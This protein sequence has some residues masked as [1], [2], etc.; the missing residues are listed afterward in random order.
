MKDKI[1]NES[2]RIYSILLLLVAIGPIVKAAISDFNEI[3]KLSPEDYTSFTAEQKASILTSASEN[4]RDI[5]IKVPDKG[6]IASKESLQRII[7]LRKWLE[8]TNDVIARTLSLE[9]Q[10]GVDS[11]IINELY[12][13]E[14]KKH[15]RVLKKPF[16]DT[17]LDA[18]TVTMLLK[19]NEID[20]KELLNYTLKLDTKTTNY[21]RGNGVD[22]NDIINDVVDIPLEYF[23]VSITMMVEGSMC[24]VLEETDV[25]DA[26]LLTII[27]WTG[28]KVKSRREISK[29]FLS[30]V[31]KAI[32]EARDIRL[33]S[34]IYINND[35]FVKTLKSDELILEDNAF[36][37]NIKS[38]LND[39]NV[40]KRFTRTGAIKGV[41]KDAKRSQELWTMK[42]LGKIE[43]RINSEENP[44][45]YESSLTIRLAPF[46]KQVPEGYEVIAEMTDIFGLWLYPED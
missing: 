23:E 42:I 29:F 18:S 31:L 27:M 26:D 13:K 2:L 21:L 14:K 30:R 46:M 40:D 20:E 25:R 35:G 9:L 12:R 10:T 6:L 43:K 41:S 8:D 44:D 5:I 34:Q 28:A 38:N 16:K 3:I 36:K 45:N 37:D 19:E 33:L 4:S 15:S 24:E 17:S 1:K 7:Q 39:S 32:D 11:A 22:A